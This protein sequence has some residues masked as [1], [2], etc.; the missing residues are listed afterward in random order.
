MDF[1]KLEDH[2]FNQFKIV[3]C[4]SQQNGDW[5]INLKQQHQAATCAQILLKQ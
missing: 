1:K 5:L 3:V 4:S 2:L